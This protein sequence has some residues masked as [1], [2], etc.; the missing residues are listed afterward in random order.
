[1]QLTL[2]IDD[3]SQTIEITGDI[4]NDAADFFSKMDRD[5]DQG[6]Q[7]SRSWVERPNL[8]QRCQIAANKILDAIND[9]NETLMMLMAGYILVRM[10]DV[11]AVRIDTAGDMTATELLTN[12]L[13]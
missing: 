10:P 9:E 8:V 13:E 11:R 3:A 2:Y 4:L 12:P 5:M 6:W 7:M 1:M